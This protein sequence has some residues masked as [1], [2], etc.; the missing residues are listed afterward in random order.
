[1]SSPFAIQNQ[2]DTIM[3]LTIGAGADRAVWCRRQQ[4]PKGGCGEL[5]S[6]G[7]NIRTVFAIHNQDRRIELLTV[8]LDGV[9]RHR[10]ETAPNGPF[11]EC[12]KFDSPS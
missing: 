5:R 9:I 2:D 11:A 1:M 8:G 4:V 12:D 7:G 10:W 6:L 3:L